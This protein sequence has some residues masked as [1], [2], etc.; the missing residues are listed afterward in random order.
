MAATK[1]VRTKDRSIVFENHLDSTFEYWRRFGGVPPLKGKRVLDFGC[2]TGGMVQRLID[3][4]AAE[5]VGVDISEYAVAYGAERLAP[6]GD[7]VK[8]Y[9]A[10]IRTL[11]VGSFDVIVSQNTL[12]HVMPLGEVT[13]AVADRAKPGADM[14]FGFSPLWYSPFGHHGY[15][16]TRLPWHHLI[17]GDKAVLDAM[18]A[19][20][21]KRYA[22]AFDAGFN[23]ATPD[24]FEAMF[25]TLPADIV[26]LRRNIVTGGWKQT[27]ASIFG[28][29]ADLPP[30]R[31]YMTVS[32]YAHLRKR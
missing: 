28:P 14:Y 23:K 7:R 2:G 31:K 19:T 18:E 24:D 17:F 6:Y 13:R 25:K 29:I 4:G 32:M 26:S 15:P 27:V 5:V 16:I 9:A 10:D 8:M 20:S 22:D 1:T 21:G 12:E 11:D 3:N 30:F